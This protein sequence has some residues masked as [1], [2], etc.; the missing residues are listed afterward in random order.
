VV[1]CGAESR[2]EY[3]RVGKIREGSRAGFGGL[4]GSSR[5]LEE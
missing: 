4:N 5:E 2:G 3:G 1:G